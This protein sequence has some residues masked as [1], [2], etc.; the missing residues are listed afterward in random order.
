[1]V[2]PQCFTGVTAWYEHVC[3]NH[4]FILNLSRLVF[5]TIIFNF[6]PSLAFCFLFAI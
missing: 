6:A 2:T 3:K 4:D 5:L 1:M